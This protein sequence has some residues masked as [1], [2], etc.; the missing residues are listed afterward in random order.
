MLEIYN[1]V[2]TDLLNPSATNLQ[3][4]EDIKRGCYVEDLS[5]QLIQNG[6]QEFEMLQGTTF[7]CRILAQ[8]LTTWGTHGSMW[9][10]GGSPAQPLPHAPTLFV[11][12]LMLCG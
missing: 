1:E 9:G 2:I 5:E 7:C 11:Q 4:R 8:Q 12:C 10:G 3:I 6:E